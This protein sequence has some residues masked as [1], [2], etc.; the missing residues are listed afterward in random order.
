[1]KPGD[2]VRSMRYRQMGIIIEIFDD[3]NKENPWVRVLFTHPS[4][5]YQWC[6]MD[7]LLP[8]KKEENLSPPLSDALNKSG[9]L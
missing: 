4:R 9:S 6:K 3:L 8:T 2:L 5:T 1:M 7:G